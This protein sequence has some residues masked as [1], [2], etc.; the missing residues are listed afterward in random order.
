MVK[1]EKV[2]AKTDR[3]L[4]GETERNLHFLSSV[5]VFSGSSVVKI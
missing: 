4:R 2:E 1:A 5:K 3:D